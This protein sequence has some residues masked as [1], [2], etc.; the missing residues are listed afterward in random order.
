MTASAYALADC[1][2]FYPACETVFRPEL[3]NRPVVVLGN[4]DGCVIARN[5]LAKTVA[6]IAMGAPLRTIQHLIKQHGVV[7]CSPNFALYGD[8]SRRV[9]DVLGTF[10]HADGIEYYSIDEAFVD[11]SAAPPAARARYAEHM[12]ATVR[13]ATG[14]VLSIGVGATKTIAKLGSDNAK[15]T[16]NGVLDVQGE[17]E[18]DALLRTLHVDDVWGIGAQRGNLCRQHGIKTAYDYKVADS[19]WVKR[20][21]SIM[22]LRTQME[23]RGIP[24]MPMQTIKEPRKNICCS[25]AFGHPLTELADLKEGIALYATRACERLREQHSLVTAISVFITTNHFR[26]DQQQYSKSVTITLPRATA[27]TAEVI[28]AAQRGI[29]RVFR[30]GMAFHKAGVTLL[31]LHDDTFVQPSMFDEVDESAE[32][33]QATID[34][35]NRRFGRDTV[36]YGAIS[37]EQPWRMKNQ[38]QSSHFTTRWD[39]LARAR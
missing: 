5:K 27:N 11:V 9:M 32:R 36:K 10:T 3:R 14:I 19:V 31:N 13:Q 6:G 15:E 4:N 39:G 28:V 37:L 23:L 34:A 16:P 20:H 8:M 7:V 18:L 24:C 21:L 35:I 12:R 25:R 26:E 17:V 30:P 33:L 29:E 2:G 38:Q 1:N 22:G